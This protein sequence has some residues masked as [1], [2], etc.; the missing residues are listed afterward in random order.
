MGH[1]RLVKVRQSRQ[2]RNFLTSLQWSLFGSVLLSLALPAAA[3]SLNDRRDESARDAVVVTASRLEQQ[4]TDVIPH[5]TVIT[6]KDIRES[7]A[8]DL[9]TLLRREAGFEFVQNGGMGNVTSI[10]MRGGDGRQVLVLIDGVR[11]GSATLGTTQIEGVMLN[12]VERVEVVR[13]NVSALYGAGAIGGVI[14]IFTKQGTG[15]PRAE[16]Q[17][18][19][20]DRNTSRLVMAYAGSVENTRFSVNLS[21]LQTGGFSAIDTKKAP[22]AN[23]D[24]DGYANLGFSAQIAQTLAAGHEVGLRAYQN[25]G[26]VEFDNAFGTATERNRA[27]N[28]VSS[29]AIYSSNQFN[30]VWHS[31]LTLAEGADKGK[32]FTDGRTPTRTD[33]RNIQLQWQNQFRLAQDHVVSAGL[34]HMSQR[35]Q[36]TTSYPVTGR[37]VSTASLAYNGRVEAHH[38]Q[39]G[40]R[41]DKYSDFGRAD[42]WLAGYAY[43]ITSDWKVTAMRSSAFTAP[44]FNQLYFPAFGNPNLQPERSTSNELGL[45]YAVGAHLLRVATYR[46]SYRNLIDTPAPTFRPQNVAAARVEG[47]EMS[48]TGQFGAWDA[49]ASLTVQDPIN[50]ATG[51]PLRRRGTTF[52]NLVVNTTISGWRLGSEFMFTGTR[53][54]NHIVSGARVTL[55]SYKLVNLIARY[56]LSKNSFVSARLENLFDERYELAQGYNVPGRGLFV[57]LGWQQ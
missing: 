51:A 18:M 17:L 31:R 16:A 20:G 38:F 2:S 46:T 35:V 57:S 19:L 26:E 52:G 13:G 32:S 28:A 4:L 41:D 39:A 45:Q 47:T 42:T 14:Q 30:P 50:T 15:A 27:E 37:E 29:Y 5:T 49:R 8:V 44:T 11:V 40:L 25:Y 53:A 56:P 34:E 6:Q 23:P 7:Q 3:Q 55:G 1:L 24:S 48:Y 54:D 12:Q 22:A 10:F 43:D 33:T 9:P 36:S 21:R